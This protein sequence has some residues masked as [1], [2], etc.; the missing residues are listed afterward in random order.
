MMDEHKEFS[1]QCD[2]SGFI[3]K[4]SAHSGEEP[5]QLIGAFHTGDQVSRL[6]EERPEKLRA[7]FCDM[8]RTL[9]TGRFIHTGSETGPGYQVFSRRELTDIPDFSEEILG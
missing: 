9:F 1:S 3:P 5:F 7:S 6:D 4:F 8:R 2:N